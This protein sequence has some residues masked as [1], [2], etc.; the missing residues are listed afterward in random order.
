MKLTT[1]NSVFFFAIESGIISK[2][3][4]KKTIKSFVWHDS[5]YLSVCV[6]SIGELSSIRAKVR[7]DNGYEKTIKGTFLIT[8]DKVAN[9]NGIRFYIIDISKYPEKEARL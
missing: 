7:V 4:K 6:A 9:I 2:H 5:V 3:R 1:S 8:F